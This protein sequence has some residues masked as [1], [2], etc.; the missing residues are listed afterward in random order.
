MRIQNIIKFFIFT[1]ILYSWGWADDGF[2]TKSR[3]PFQ[4]RNQFPINL[5]FLSFTADDA[6]TLKKNKFQL[7]INYSHTNMFAQSTDVLENLNH[8]QNRVEWKHSGTGQLEGTNIIQ[9]NYL[10]DTESSR[11]D[12]NIKYGLKGNL[13][14]GV[15]I[16]FISYHGGFLDAPIELVHQ[17]AG[18]PNYNR[19]ILKKNNSQFYLSTNQKEVFLDSNEFTDS[20]I[21]DI[22]LSAKGKLYESLNREFTLASR[23]SIKIPSG[24]Y[25]Q[26]RG[27]GSLDYGIE[28]TVSKRFSNSIISSNVSGVFPGQWKLFPGIKINPIF[29][30][31][32]SYEYFWGNRLSLI[33]QNLLQN[34]YLGQEV[35]QEISKPIFEWTAG[36]KYDI[37]KRYQL[38]FAVTENYIYHNNTSDFGFHV[39]ISRGF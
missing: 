20:G 17:I 13:T 27:S 39:G 33:L 14:V 23:I 37:G 11:F 21:G 6:F 30:W 3:G 29:S 8:T 36:I 4:I 24:D 1:I 15:T 19:S 2:Y 12:F 5:Q 9:N 32:L 22:V 18:F 10:F 7:R 28:L 26:L 38:S 35:H 16:P 34:S 25:R 31:I